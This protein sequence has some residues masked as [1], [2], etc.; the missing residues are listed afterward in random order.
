M[1]AVA[2]GARRERRDGRTAIAEPRLPVGQ[3]QDDRRRSRGQLPDGDHHVRIRTNMQIYWD[4][5]F[6]ARDA[7]SRDGEDR[8]RSR[9]CPPTCTSAA[10]RGCIARAVATVRTG[11]TTTSVSKES[12]WRPIEGAFTRFG[13]VLPLL[14]RPDDMYVIMAPG[15]ETTL[16]FDASV[17]RRRCRKAGRATSSS[18]PTAGSRTPI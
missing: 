17:R 2:R 3:G 7:T 5:A 15:D 13:D 10:S 14:D 1:I 6:V 4:Q 11:S 9:R 8:R 12:P 16:E 18:T